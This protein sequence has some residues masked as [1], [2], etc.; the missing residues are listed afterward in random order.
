MARVTTTLCVLVLLAAA[1][2]PSAVAQQNPF[3][4][5]PQAPPEQTAPPTN[6]T[7]SSTDGNGGLSR[8]Q[9]I[10]LACAG[11]VLLFGIGYAIVRDA[12]RSAPVLA[13]RSEEEGGTRSKGSRTPK[14][15]RVTQG[16]TRA[17][18]A[19]RSRKKNR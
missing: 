11:F 9:E 4:P 5:I 6:T 3:G 1:G 15:Q 8:R 18:A 13:H 19:R 2:A 10:L 12:R 7:S 14:Q 17:K 16:R